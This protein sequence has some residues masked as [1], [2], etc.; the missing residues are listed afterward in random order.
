MLSLTASCS[1][2]TCICYTVTFILHTSWIWL[3]TYITATKCF[4]D[5][6]F[7]YLFFSM[8]VCNNFDGLEDLLG[9]VELLSHEIDVMRLILNRPKVN[10][11]NLYP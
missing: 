4:S 2:S 6:V 10:T 3:C 9:L 7:Y 8:C 11:K 1:E 5:V